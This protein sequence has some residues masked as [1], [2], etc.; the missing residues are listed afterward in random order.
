MAFKNIERNRLD[1]ILT[2]IMPLEL[3]E[4]FSYRAFYEYLLSQPQKL[5]DITSSVQVTK[6][7]GNKKLF[8]DFIS[9]VPLK[10]SIL[11]GTDSIRGI[12]LI[13][14]FSAVA[15]YLFIE[16]YQKEI[17]YYFEEHAVFSV[18]YHKKNS[19]LFYKK[20][21]N[22]TSQYFERIARK[23]KKG[24]LQ[25]NGNFFSIYPYNSVAGFTSSK[26]WQYCNFKYKYYAKIDYK[27]CFDSIYSHSFKWIIQKNTNDSKNAANGNL[28]VVI[29]A[30]LQRIN[31]RSSNGVIVGPEFSR[32][33]AEILLQHI[34]C[35]V[36]TKLYSKG[37]YHKKDYRIFRYVDDVYI[38]ARTQSAVDIIIKCYEKVAEVYLLHLNE[39]KFHK[40]ET[41]VVVSR[42]IVDTRNLADKISSLFYGKKEIR[43]MI[44]EAE[45]EQERCLLKDGYIPLERLKT[46]FNCLIDEHKKDKR[47]IVSFLLSTLLNNI[48]SK[49][50]GYILFHAERKNKAFALLEFAM[51]VY[52]FCPCFEHT[53]RIIS[54]IVYINSELDFKENLKNHDKLQSLI[55]KYEFVFERYNLNDLCN[56]F[57]LFYEYKISLHNNVEEYIIA[58]LKQE[59][60]PILWA[61]YLIYSKYYTEYN[62]FVLQEVEKTI[63]DNLNRFVGDKDIMMYR[64][65]WYI[66]IFYNCPH[67]SEHVKDRLKG[68]IQRLDDESAEEQSKKIKGLL[69]DFMKLERCSG[70]F[71]WSYNNMDMSM[72]ITYRTHQ[73]TLFKNYKNK[74]TVGLF[75]SLD[76]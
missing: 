67:L 8:D 13:Q 31:G 23:L 62:K 74:R 69:C 50:D 11:K 75:G 27:S 36:K 63:N 24:V 59:N 19:E 28:F 2:D 3:S 58:L 33:I 48:S 39:L 65:F 37:I 4:L 1:Y 21:N 40:C 52:S 5:K 57:L 18:R 30:I 44:F 14:P 42:W 66:L 54:M 7:K 26:M 61:N 73:R 46:E 64:E 68:Y 35:E 16:C 71:N 38:F 17:L 29:D 47:F 76:F 22:K 56:W 45:T 32:M 34:D 6:A 55:R 20:R 43:K 72:Q 10:Y 9:T 12:N 41:P 70:F 25:Q 15:L 51:Y 60:N 49:K 53:Q